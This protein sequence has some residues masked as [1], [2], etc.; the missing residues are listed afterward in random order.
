[1]AA[2]ETSQ[3]AIS[4]EALPGSQVALTIEVPADEVDRA[5]ENVIAKLSQKAKIQGFRPGKAPRAVVEARLGAPVIREEA[6]EA[7]VPEVVNRALTESGIE[8]IDRPRVD[9][10]E[11]ERGKPARFTATVS[12]MPEVELADLGSIRVERPH[13]E[14]TTEMVDRRVEELLDSQSTLEP[15]ERPVQEG[16][17]IVADLDVSAD[18]K[19]VPSAGRRAMEME[20]KEGVL[21][22]ELREAVIGKSTDEVAEA[23][24][25]MPADAADAELANKRANLRL[26]VR[27]VKQKNVPPLNDR[28]A[29]TISNGEQKTA[30]ELKIAVRKDL[31]ETA[32]RFD[33]LAHEQKVLEAVVE[34]S[35]V[36]VPATLVD[37]EV[38]HQLEDLEQRIQRQGLRLDRYF[39]YSG[40]TAQE[41]AAKA[42][43][44]AESRLKVDMVLGE[45]TKKLGVNPTTEEVYA[46][47]MSEAAKDDELKGQLDQLTQNRSAVEYFRHRLTRLKTLESLVAMA[48]GEKPAEPNR[49]TSE[50]EKEGA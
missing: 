3:L 10:L 12:V 1:M 47:L 22:P 5:F 33:E 38:A 8:P 35:R 13:T 36:E 48:S 21:I 40:T 25:D 17:V 45:A 9:V 44:D 19:E 42:R 20:V 39:A 46:Y 15:V 37:H 24:V 2:P 27:G 31:E 32:K 43:P 6:I 49:A 28:T 23:E 34:G 41:W 14:V 4:R 11:F 18:G 50:S 29:E 30:L 26:T 7:L 16:D